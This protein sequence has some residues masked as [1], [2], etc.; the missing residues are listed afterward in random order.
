MVF[1]YPRIYLETCHLVCPKI[2]LAGKNIK[3]LMVSRTLRE[4]HLLE[5]SLTQNPVDHAPL[6]TTSHVGLHVSFSS[7]NFLWA[8]RPSPPSVK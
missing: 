7:T 5:V 4:V 2:C 6:S 1:V 8:F 3:K